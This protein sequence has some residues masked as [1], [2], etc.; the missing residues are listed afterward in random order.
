MADGY[1]NQQRQQHPPSGPLKRH[2][3]DFEAPP[4][5]MASGREMHGGYFPRDEDLDVPDTRTIGSAYDRYLQSVQ[6]PSGEA[7]PRNGV[8]MGRPGGNGQSMGEF[9]MRR[10]G[11]VP[12]EHGLD[13]RGMGFDPQESVDRRNREP[14]PLPPDASNTLYDFLLS[15]FLNR[16]L[17]IFRPFVGYR[18]VRLVTKDS[19]HRNG[20]PI[21]LCFVDF[22]NPACAATA[23]STLQGYRM[24]ESEPDSKFLRLQFSRKPG[25][26]P[27]QRGRR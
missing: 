10:G 13:G 20:D 25:S 27:G 22:T 21:V 17:D 24:D 12:Q 9:M 4:S 23:L 5:A 7:G 16:G 18:E 26:R 3:S 14:L 15:S 6:T 1:W 2:R 11:V 8:A 19:K